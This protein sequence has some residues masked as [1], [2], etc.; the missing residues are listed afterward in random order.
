MLNSS[1]I[2]PASRYIMHTVPLTLRRL[3]KNDE[4]SSFTCTFN[5]PF[6]E[7][8]NQLFIP[9]M[10]FCSCILGVEF[11]ARMVT[12][13]GKQIKLQIWD[14][15]SMFTTAECHTIVWLIKETDQ[16]RQWWPQTVMATWYSMNGHKQCRPW[17]TI[18]VWVC[19]EYIVCWRRWVAN[20]LWVKLLS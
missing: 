11:G 14:T 13:D 3:L 4:K 20:L 7:W 16:V 9:L 18:I 2:W 10:W 17:I 8:F 15:V 6:I 12:I 1:V 19:F 5:L